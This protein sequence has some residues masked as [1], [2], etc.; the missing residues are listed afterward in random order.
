MA[1][2]TDGVRMDVFSII[3]YVLAEL[4]MMWSTVILMMI[5][6]VRVWCHVRVAVRMVDMV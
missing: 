2:Y 4:S 5:G 3:L 6:A 1:V